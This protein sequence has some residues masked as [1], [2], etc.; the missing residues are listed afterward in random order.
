MTQKTSVQRLRDRIAS[1]ATLRDE[2][3]RLAPSD[4]ARLTEIQDHLRRTGKNMRASELRAIKVEVEIIFGK[5]AK[6]LPDE[7]IVEH[8]LGDNLVGMLTDEQVDDRIVELAAK[9]A[10][11]DPALAERIRKAGITGTPAASGEATPQTTH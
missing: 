11:L 3:V 9:A 1:R 7:K 2:F 10:N 8:E 5:L 6:V 4:Q